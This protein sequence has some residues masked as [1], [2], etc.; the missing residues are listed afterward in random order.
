MDQMPPKTD[1]SSRLNWLRPPILTRGRIWFALSVA[2]LTDGLQLLLGPLGWVFIDET[3]DVLAMA[4][5]SAALGFHMLLL[6]TFLLEFLPG[7]DLMPTWTGCAVA[8][9]MLRKRPQPPA[10]PPHI[11][12]YSEVSAM[13]SRDAQDNSG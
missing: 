11:N 8:V 4:L 6:P 10:A 12:V 9:I 5:T 2:V 13:P 1:S 3:L 7:P